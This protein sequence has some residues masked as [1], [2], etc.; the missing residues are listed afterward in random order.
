MILLRLGRNVVMR[1]RTTWNSGEGLL[2]S[3]LTE[4]VV[5]P[6]YCCFS[7]LTVHHSLFPFHCT[8]LERGLRRTLQT[9]VFSSS[10]LRA[11]TRFHLHLQ[12][13]VQHWLHLQVQPPERVP[14]TTSVSTKET[15]TFSRTTISNTSTC[16]NS[17]RATISNTASCSEERISSKFR[18]N[19]RTWSFAET[20]AWISTRW[21]RNAA[22]IHIWFW[23]R[24]EFGSICWHFD[25]SFW[26]SAW[27]CHRSRKT[28]HGLGPH[29]GIG[30]ARSEHWLSFVRP[31]AIAWPWHSLNIRE[32]IFCSLCADPG[33]TFL[34]GRPGGGRNAVP[35]KS[36]T[37][38]C[39][40]R[41]F[42]LSLTRNVLVGCA[43]LRDHPLN[44]STE[45]FNTTYYLSMVVL[46]LGNMKRIPYFANGKRYPRHIRENWAE[47]KPRLVLP[48]LVV[49][50]PGHII[51]LCESYDFVN[52][53]IS[54]LNTILSEF[55]LGRFPSG[56][57]LDGP[58]CVSSMYLVQNSRCP[59]GNTRAHRTPI[60][61]S[62]SGIFCI[63][64]GTLQH[65]WMQKHCDSRRPT[66]SYWTIRGHQNSYFEAVDC[67]QFCWTT[68]HV[69]CACVDNLSQFR[70]FSLLD[71]RVRDTLRAIF[72]KALMSHTD[73]ITGDFNFFANR[74]F[75][76]DQCGTYIGGIVVEVLEDVVA[77]MNEHL[78]WQNKITY[79]ISS[80]DS[81][82]RSLIPSCKVRKQQ[83]WTV[84]CAFLSST[85]VR[86]LRQI[87][88]QELLRI[89]IWHLIIYILFRKGL[90]SCWDTTFA[91]PSDNDW[92]IP[93]IVRTSAY[94]TRNKRTR[95]Q[96]A[97][98]LRHQRCREYLDRSYQY[99][100]QSRYH[101]YWQD[102][103]SHPYTRSSSSS[104]Q[105]WDGWYGGW[106]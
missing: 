92:H 104:G 86:N 53:L 35:S 81:S 77:A 36:Y 93:L 29:Y 44:M 95:G 26:Y 68:R 76:T 14:K 73:F 17:P 32:C 69:R 58:R 39:R 49:N 97:L 20:T 91:K 11:A 75:K 102:H 9:S 61:R 80:F 1:S 2:H 67:L 106:R 25:F 7:F 66:W 40:P 63:F 16:T 59:W 34:L 72:A 52:I 38:H 18:H 99:Q 82:T 45:Y 103:G 37:P 15:W 8:R 100:Q 84:C 22:N 71:T 88:L 54:V 94:S 19:G 96:G 101:G 48:H 33:G 85:A 23:Y 13:Q 47:M 3:F 105:N 46:N 31:H 56:R 6:V 30:G 55:K 57:L 41:F 83:T 4:K 51:T 12:H 42:T 21:C 50:N 87:D 79:N 64:R 43:V 62:I 70:C 98:D 89:Y 65:T 5:R 27:R 74:Q 78:S 60:L 10:S 24:H 90:D 28:T